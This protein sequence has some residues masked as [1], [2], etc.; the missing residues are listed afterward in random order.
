M[1]IYMDNDKGGTWD[2]SCCVFTF[3]PLNRDWQKLPKLP[4]FYHIVALNLRWLWKIPAWDYSI[5]AGFGEVQKIG[6]LCSF[7]QGGTWWGNFVP[8]AVFDFAKSRILYKSIFTSVADVFSVFE[9]KFAGYSSQKH[10]EFWRKPQ[11]N[12]RTVKIY[13][14]NA[15]FLNR[16]T[17]RFNLYPAEL[18]QDSKFQELL[19]QN[20]LM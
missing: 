15:L 9:A 6:N 8:P 17:K 20:L 12:V 4:N 2:D 16:L 1:Y 18:W 3:P 19:L 14:Q 11:K 7:S 10:S 13:Y 5:H